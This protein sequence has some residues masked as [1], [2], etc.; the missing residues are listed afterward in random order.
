MIK[1]IETYR[2]LKNKYSEFRTVAPKKDW[3]TFKAGKG[4]TAQVCEHTKLEKWNCDCIPEKEKNS[5]CD[6][7]LKCK[8]CLNLFVGKREIRPTVC[9][10]DPNRNG[11]EE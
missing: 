2:S 11:E 8:E 6:I 7:T 4:F 5:C 10:V 3:K 1:T 9:L